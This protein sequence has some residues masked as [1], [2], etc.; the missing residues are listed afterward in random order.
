MKKMFKIICLVLT[1][2]LFSFNSHASNIYDLI[3]KTIKDCK[4]VDVVMT[5]SYDYL[6]MCIKKNEDNKDVLY[7]H[8]LYTNGVSSRKEL[9]TIEDVN[10]ALEK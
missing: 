6:I 5:T 4:I 2:C 8:K 9:I 7:Y 3:G 1:F 10:K